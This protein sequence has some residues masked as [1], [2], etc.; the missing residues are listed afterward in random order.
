MNVLARLLNRKG[1]AVQEQA[2]T[3]APIEAQAPPPAPEPPAKPPFVVTEETLGLSDEIARTRL[4]GREPAHRLTTIGPEE[5]VDPKQLEA[6]RALPAYRNFL[7]K[8]K[9]PPT[10]GARR[11]HIP[12]EYG[13]GPRRQ[14]RI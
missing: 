5:Q 13:G 14:P 3:P 12:E 1:K 4:P 2:A 7:E 10:R 11:F 6:Y 9:R 8:A